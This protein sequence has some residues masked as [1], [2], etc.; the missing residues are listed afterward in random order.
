MPQQID[1]K[2]NEM[3]ERLSLNKSSILQLEEGMNATDYE[4]MPWRPDDQ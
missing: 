3:F 2:L 4:E 1:E